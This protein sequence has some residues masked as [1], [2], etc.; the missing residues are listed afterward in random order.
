MTDSTTTAGVFSDT[1]AK[2]EAPDDWDTRGLI[3]YTVTRLL[4]CSMPES[5]GTVRALQGAIE[6]IYAAIIASEGIDGNRTKAVRPYVSAFVDVKAIEDVAAGPVA[7]DAAGIEKD[8]DNRTRKP[9]DVC[10]YCPTVA[11]EYG[12]ADDDEPDSMDCPSCGWSW[13]VDPTATIGGDQ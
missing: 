10:D 7:L 3:E 4:A 9:G 11:L 8:P 12:E 5:A 13:A 6:T 1:L 2:F